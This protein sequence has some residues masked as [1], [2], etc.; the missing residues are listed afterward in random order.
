M[1]TPLKDYVIVKI[2]ENQYKNISTEQSEYDSLNQG[3][4]VDCGEYPEL[5]DKQV[6]YLTY[7]EK[8]CPFTEDGVKY[9]IIKHEE[10][11][12]IV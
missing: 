4:V 6:I 11:R 5:E 12:G 10:I 1:Y 7:K 9:A 3:T 8:D 2:T